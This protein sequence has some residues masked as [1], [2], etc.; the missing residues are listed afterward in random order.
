M[1]R[2]I[3]I[4]GGMGP[5]ATCDLFRKIIAITDTAC[6]QA[7]IRVNI[8]NTEISDR[9]VAPTVCSRWALIMPCNAAHYFHSCVAKTVAVPLW[10]MLRK[11]QNTPNRKAL[12]ALDCWQQMA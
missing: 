6:D 2:T 11:L 12:L 5:L 10:N 4:I 7:H 1:K 9:T 3:G 8:D